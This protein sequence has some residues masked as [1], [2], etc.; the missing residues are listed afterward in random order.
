MI[1]SE[2]ECMEILKEKNVPDNVIAHSIAV[3]DVAEEIADNIIKKGKK[4]NKNLIIAAALLHDIARAKYGDHTIEGVKE[5]EK[6][7]L[8]EVAEVSGTHSLHL[9]EQHEP[10]TTEQKILF[11]ADK[12]AKHGK[13]V[14]LEERFEDFKE[15]YGGKE[16]LWK[17]GYDF[18]K[19]IEKELTK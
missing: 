18:A 3:K 10:K 8:H 6:L 17:K 14:T 16:E 7:G 11:Y 4:V 9:I 15:R 1:P 5:L 2:K 12:V 13:K 19:K